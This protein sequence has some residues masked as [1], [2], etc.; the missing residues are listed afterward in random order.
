MPIQDAMS[1][2]VVSCRFDTPLND[3]AGMMWEY[4]C[5]AI[6]VVGN[7]GRLAGMITDRDICMAAYTQ[8]RPLHAL[9]AG[10][11]MSKEAFSCRPTDELDSA[12]RLMTERMVR[13]VP[14]VNGD[15]QLVG[16]LSLADL[17]RY[18]SSRKDNLQQKVMQVFTTI[19]QPR[20]G[21]Q[22]QP[23]PTDT[24]RKPAQARA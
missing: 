22:Q 11:A 18:A 23:P 2:R 17:A 14:I 20:P 19:S 1:T 15:R 4:D 5:G 3:V 9:Y 12:L 24:M 21:A 10:Q 7:D 6:P 13:R 8:G 16:M